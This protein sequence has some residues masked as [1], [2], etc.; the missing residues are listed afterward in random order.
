[1]ANCFF[2]ARRCLILIGICLAWSLSCMAQ[3]LQPTPTAT[4]RFC[5]PPPPLGGSHGQGSGAGVGSAST[6]NEVKVV[7]TNK[8]VTKK[9]EI[10]LAPG[11]GFTTAEL[12]NISEEVKL[13]VVL[14]PK[15]FVSNIKILSKL[16]EAA[17]EK[18]IEAARNIRFIPAEKD[19]KRVAQYA[20]IVYSNSTY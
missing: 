18:A 14:C 10:L 11:P 12:D 5:L 16:P 17:T 20:T 8:E 9:A 4:E 2:S 3:T 7:F 6:D 15:G 1:M 13:R 19:G